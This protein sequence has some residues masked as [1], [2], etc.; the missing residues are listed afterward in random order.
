MFKW[1]QKFKD[2]GWDPSPDSDGSDTH[3]FYG[4]TDLIGY[5]FT[6][7]NRRELVVQRNTHPNNP[8]PR[9]RCEISFNHD[10]LTDTAKWTYWDGKKQHRNLDT[11]PL[12]IIMISLRLQA[13]MERLLND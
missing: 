1:H 6:M 13:E 3:G 2:C 9:N 10:L 4:K 12:R 7:N 11:A 8:N 5:F